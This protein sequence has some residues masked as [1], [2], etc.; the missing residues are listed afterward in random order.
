MSVRSLFPAGLLKDTIQRSR[1]QV[2]TGFARNGHAAWF[3]EV[4]EL[5]VAAFRCDENPPIFAQSVQD[6]ADLHHASIA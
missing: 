3:G 6:I 2:I 5:T 1:R 4:L